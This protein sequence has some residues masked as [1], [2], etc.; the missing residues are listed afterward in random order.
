MRLLHVVSSHHYY[1]AARE[2]GKT[3]TIRGRNTNHQQ[4][5]QVSGAWGIAALMKQAVTS[6]WAQR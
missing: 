3:I 4:T 1:A 6:Q 2:M 5:R